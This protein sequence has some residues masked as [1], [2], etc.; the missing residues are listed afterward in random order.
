M[1]ISFRDSILVDEQRRDK[2]LELFS[3]NPFLFLTWQRRYQVQKMRSNHS[4]LKY[5]L[6]RNLFGV[7]SAI[8]KVTKVDN[9]TSEATEANNVV[10][11][12]EAP[13]S[14]GK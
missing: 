13:T 2:E 8:S 9:T 6:T 7:I 10:L 14:I 5:L 11:K 3:L 12:T 4:S 1:S